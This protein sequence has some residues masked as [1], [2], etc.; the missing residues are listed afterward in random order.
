MCGQQV[1]KYD[2]TSVKVN[3]FGSIH[4]CNVYC[5][6]RAIVSFDHM[7]SFTTKPYPDGYIRFGPQYYLFLNW[8]TL[9]A[10]VARRIIFHKSYQ[11]ISIMND[12]SI[13]RFD[14]LMQSIYLMW[15]SAIFERVTSDLRAI[16]KSHANKYGLYR[17]THFS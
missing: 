9:T 10:K 5:E 15:Q 16:N 12:I 2:M 14:H 4:Q 6:S 13:V 17:R 11:I 8:N 7:F 3:I 1:E